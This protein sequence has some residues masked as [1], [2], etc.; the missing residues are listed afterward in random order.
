MRFDYSQEW[1]ISWRLGNI[2]GT[3]FVCGAP[4]GLFLAVFLR[5]AFCPLEDSIKISPFLNWLVDKVWMGARGWTL[6][7]GTS[8]WL[9]WEVSPHFPP[10]PENVK[11]LYPAELSCYPNSYLQD[12]KHQEIRSL[13]CFRVSHCSWNLGIT[14]QLILPRASDDFG[15]FHCPCSLFTGLWGRKKH[16]SFWRVSF[17]FI[18]WKVKWD[19]WE[20]LQYLLFP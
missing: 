17:Q 7:S 2:S 3:G 4:G 19:S 12:L 10:T 11:E 13:R 20:H 18:V 14:F 9:Q 6:F 16:F 1:F 8:N 15:C 5:S